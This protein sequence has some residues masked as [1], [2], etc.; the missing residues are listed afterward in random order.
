MKDKAPSFLSSMWFS[1][2]QN[3]SDLYLNFDINKNQLEFFN[4]LFSSPG[5]DWNGQ[6]IKVQVGEGLRPYLNDFNNLRLGMAVTDQQIGFQSLGVAGFPGAAKSSD[7]NN[8]NFTN[9]IPENAIFYLEGSNL[10]KVLA[11][12]LDELKRGVSDRYAVAIF[13]AGNNLDLVLIASVKDQNALKNNLAAIKTKY[14]ESSSESNLKYS[15]DNVVDT[16]KTTE[17]T[18]NKDLTLVYGLVGDKLVFVTSSEGFRKIVATSTHKMGSL[19]GNRDYFSLPKKVLTG[20]YNL[21][22][23]LKTENLQE[24]AW[25]H[26]NSLLSLDLKNNL[27]TL[28][29]ITDKVS[30]IAVSVNHDQPLR[31]VINLKS[32]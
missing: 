17:V 21:F 20:D 4:K 12:H 22:L 3:Q 5:F 32:P 26:F 24:S 11:L 30:N 27:P 16:V 28:K 2:P 23:R 7:L 8:Q 6:T 15:F 14:L 25:T 19:S 10:D 31:G 13:P 18:V 29:A 1:F 9:I